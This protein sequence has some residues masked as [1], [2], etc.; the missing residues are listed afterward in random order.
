MKRT[1]WVV[2]GVVAAS[3]LCSSAVFAGGWGP[4]FT[5]ARETPSAGFPGFVQDIVVD[6][7]TKAGATQAEIDAARA[8][9]NSTDLDIN[10]DHLGFGVNYDSAPSRDKLFNYRMTLGWDIATHVNVENGQINI[11]GFGNLPLSQVSLDDAS[12]Y[13]FNFKNT[14]G[15][16]IIRNDLL[17]WWI[18]PAI[19]LNFDYWSKN[20]GAEAATLSVGGGAETG[21]NFHI[22]DQYSL[23][24]GGGVLW[25]A[26]GYAAGFNDIGSFVWGNGPYYFV[27]V[28]ALYHTGDDQMAR[29]SVAPAPV[30]APAPEE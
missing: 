28:S 10:L 13:G 8:A 21:V 9:M 7:M 27:Q 25:N 19:D 11:P 6:A 15:F 20:A 4:F 12:S 18:G 17:K 2:L 23:C 1:R 24:V 16:G 26:F 30:A 29:Q 5:W 22:A 14:F 3:L